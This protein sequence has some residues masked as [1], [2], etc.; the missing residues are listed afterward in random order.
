[1]KNNL[2]PAH[3]VYLF[4]RCVTVC[5]NITD[6]PSVL[7]GKTLSLD[8]LCT[9]VRLTP[10]ILEPLTRVFCLIPV[11]VYKLWLNT[12][13]SCSNFHNR[14][15]IRFHKLRTFLVC[16]RIATYKRCRD[17]EAKRHAFYTPELDSGERSALHSGKNFVLF[18]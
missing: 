15:K 3:P 13:G 2:T 17:V 7:T 12:V 16:L 10:S 5:V 9:S 18:G 4:Q 8:R 11:R 14:L 1:L 6:L